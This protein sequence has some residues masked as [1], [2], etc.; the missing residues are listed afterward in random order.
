MARIFRPTKTAMQSGR[1]NTRDWVLQFEP[2]TR[3]TID[4]LMGWTSSTDTAADQILLR[5]ATKEAAIAYAEREGIDYTLDEP[6]VA[7]PR[8]KSYAQNFRWDRPR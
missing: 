8:P 7:P 4:P 2:V 6:E 5:F 1:G 3:K